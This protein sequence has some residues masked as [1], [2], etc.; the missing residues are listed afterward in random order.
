MHP[1]GGIGRPADI[2]GGFVYLA[3]DEAVWITGTELTIDGGLTAG[4]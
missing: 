1:L 2:A 4:I 3:S